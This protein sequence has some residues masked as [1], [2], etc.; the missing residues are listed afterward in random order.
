MNLD[1]TSV[2]VV[3]ALVVNVSGI[4]FIL[5]TLLRRDEGA[6]RV[7]AIAF[8]AAMLT[9]L[10]YI[11]WVQQPAAWGAVAVG[12]SAFVVG[13]G[14]L[15]L[16]CRRFNER[17]IDWA[18]ALV[19][20]AALGAA[21]AV[22]AAGPDG[23]DWAGAVWMFI[24]LVVFAGAGAVE[25]MRGALGE[26]RSAWVL[27]AVLAA[28]SLYYI[29]RTTA[30]LTSGP[31]SA[32]FQTAFGTVPTSLVT[33]V[34]TIVAVVVASVLRASRVPMR[35]FVGS[36][37][38]VESDGIMPTGAFSEAFADVCGR[39]RERGD[40]LAVIAVRIDDLEQISTAFGSEAA[41][42]ITEVLRL[43]VR[44][45]ARS[46]A[47]VAD[48][49]PTGLLVGIV[50]DS[51]REA[52][53]QAALIYRGLFDDLGAA[54]GEVIPVVGVGLAVSETTGYELDSLIE[55]AREAAQR[56]AHSVD[57]AVLVGD[58]E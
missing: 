58:A 30:F 39:A 28:Q 41:R 40:P 24:P 35:G 5:E 9:T 20:L 33:I 18:S 55:V 3:T 54:G 57:N 4:L 19:G 8:L 31:E 45:H 48:D 44:R 11:I 23:G 21:G 34:L 56:A 13:T 37:F 25:C 10:S 15:W 29:S 52:R 38:I 1:S 43:G 22:V 32:L 53:R 47:C 46:H 7:W 51:E 2:L 42:A 26:S 6:G 14:C 49:G 12:N 36:T 27:A 17:R 16:G 50:V